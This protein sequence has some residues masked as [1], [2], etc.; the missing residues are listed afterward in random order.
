MNGIRCPVSRRR[1]AAPRTGKLYAARF[2][3]FRVD[4]RPAHLP[5]LKLSFRGDRPVEHQSA[6]LGIFAVHAE[7]TQPE[8]LVV[9]GGL[10]IGQR[11][12]QFAAL[13]HLQ[14]VG[15]QAVQ[16]VLIPGVR[17]G[18]VNRLSYRR[19]WASTAVAASTQWRV[20]PFTLR[21]SAGS[22]PR[23][24]IILRQHFHHVARLVLDAAGAGDEV[25]P[26]QAA[27]RPAGEGRL[28]LGT[29]VSRKS[30]DSRYR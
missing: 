25:G 19:T 7:V 6:G 15:V 9:G 29:G 8:E 4:R 1:N 3:R 16:E 11:G 21:P 10:G 26:L 2:Y 17:V 23:E 18:S 12:L 22:P 24:G 30:S 14:G 13:Q 28:Y 20:A 5:G 27:L